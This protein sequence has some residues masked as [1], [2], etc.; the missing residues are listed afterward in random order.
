MRQLRGYLIF[1]LALATGALSLGVARSAP[2]SVFPVACH[3]GALVAAIHSANAGRGHLVLATDCTYT[4]RAADNNK[5]SQ[6]PAG[7]HRRDDDRRQPGHHR[8]EQ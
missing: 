3:A 4:L 2:A 1:T 6:W 7:D 5:G 8:A